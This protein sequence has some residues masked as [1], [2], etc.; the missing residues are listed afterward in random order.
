M[1][2][3]NGSAVAGVARRR[4]PP[5]L[6]VVCAA[7]VLALAGQVGAEGTGA[8]APPADR[9][10]VYPYEL[11]PLPYPADALEPFIDAETMAIHHGRHHAAYVN[12]LNAALEKHPEWQK[13]PL[14]ELL[15]DLA[16]LPESLRAAVRNNG[17]G[18]LNH[19]LFWQVMAPDAGGEPGGELAAAIQKTFGSFAAFQQDMN[20][21]ATGRFGSGWAWLSVDGVGALR[22][23]STANQDTPLMDGR[24]PILGVDVWEHAYYLKY[25]WR[26][27]DYLTAWWR[28][29]NW[30]EV[31][32]RW[33]QARAA[34]H[35]P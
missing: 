9:A 35:T 10:L 21:A 25:Q 26:R 14:R 30:A 13:T 17:G 1:T 15:A 22:V 7:A 29:V 4:W 16:A 18:H 31:N 5:V 34:S 8:G 24:T 27:A 28:T 32:R 3:R 20:R 6:G 12:N 11:P 33:L 19:A 2:A 23:E